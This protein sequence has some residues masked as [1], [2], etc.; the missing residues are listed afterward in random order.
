MLM[1][2]GS[3]VLSGFD[4]LRF[5]SGYLYVVEMLELELFFIKYSAI[6]NW[7][8]KSWLCQAYKEAQGAPP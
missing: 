1:A 7:S 4:A 2:L 6:P 5:Y 3:A 8:Y